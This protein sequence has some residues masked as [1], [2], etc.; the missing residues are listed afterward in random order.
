MST[1]ERSS[2]DAVAAAAYRPRGVPI[3]EGNFKEIIGGVVYDCH[4]KVIGE[5]WEVYLR[6]GSRQPQWLTV[7]TSLFRASEYFV[8]LAGAVRSH[9][10]V[11][12]NH[13]NGESSNLP[14]S[15]STTG[16]SPSGS[17]ATVPPLRPGRLSAGSPI[18][19]SHPPPRA[20]GAA[21]AWPEKLAESSGAP[22]PATAHSSK[23]ESRYRAPLSDRVRVI[24]AA[25]PLSECASWL[26]CPRQQASVWP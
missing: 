20:A 12:V 14:A 9:D 18:S 15:M 10:G 3:H 7:R 23:V 25:R 13:D 2:N 26:V 11:R 22:P 17:E 21:P 24:L 19:P 16:C 4:Y 1:N 5:A 8:P 6:E